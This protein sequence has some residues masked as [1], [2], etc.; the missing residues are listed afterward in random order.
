[1]TFHDVYAGHL[2]RVFGFFAYRLE[3]REE[4]EDLTQQTFERALRAWQRYDPTRAS[5]ATWL[6]AIASNLL[7]DHFRARS[8]R[9]SEARID[10]H[11]DHRVLSVEDDYSLH[12]L[13]PEI[14]EALAELSPRDR[15]IIALR[16]GGDMAAPEIAAVTGL[17][18]DNVHQ[19]LSRALRRLRSGLAPTRRPFREPR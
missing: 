2:D 10:D 3:S 18:V 11:E 7:I 12:E 19:I 14:A 15:E 16:F 6:L 4:A 17:S 1:M 13:D 9:E 5:P 8:K